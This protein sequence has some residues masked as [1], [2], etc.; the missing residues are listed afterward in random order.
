VTGL[1]ARMAL[2]GVGDWAMFGLW[3]VLAGF[4]LYNLLFAG[5]IE[6]RE[7][8]KREAAGEDAGG[9]RSPLAAA[10][11]RAQGLFFLAAGG[12]GIARS[13]AFF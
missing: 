11:P 8:A 1:D 7:A 12:F 3:V 4:G 2:W 5:R 10:G 13:L 9:Y 6:A